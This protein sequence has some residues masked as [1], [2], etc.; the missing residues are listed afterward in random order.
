M[1]DAAIVDLYWQRSDR[2]LSETD[3]KY[4]RYCHSIAYHI[5]LEWC[6]LAH[7]YVAHNIY[8]YCFSVL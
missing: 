1:E 5:W 3:K 6:C 2:A 7:L 4:G 8:G